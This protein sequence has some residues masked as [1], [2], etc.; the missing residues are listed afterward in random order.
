MRA[1]I[2][3][4]K[5]EMTISG[6]VNVPGR[7]S[8]AMRSPRGMFVEQI[9][10]GAFGK[11]LKNGDPVGLMF[12]HQRLLG[13][14]S[15]PNVL[16]LDEDNIGLYA[17]ATTRDAEVIEAAE[18]GHLRG[19]SF[20][21]VPLRDRWEDGEPEHRY[22]DELELYEV[23]IL[24]KTPAYI[25]TSIEARGESEVYVENRMADEDLEIV[26]LPEERVEPEP[27]EREAPA[28]DAILAELELEK[29]RM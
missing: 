26:V 15:D 13:D 2:R 19:W 12:N 29:W 8:R 10:P 6:Y 1:E 5:S 3:A 22:I 7:N 18:A 25:A 20:G 9:T 17:V 24:T 27:E 28:F 23:S 4:D 14:S 21:F 11:A 16:Q